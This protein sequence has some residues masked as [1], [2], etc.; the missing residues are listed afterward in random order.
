MVKKSLL[1]KYIQ[2]SWQPPFILLYILFILV[3]LFTD[4]PKSPKLIFP[5]KKISFLNSRLNYLITFYTSSLGS[6]WHRHL[7]Q[8]VSFV[9]LFF[10]VSKYSPQQVFSILHIGTPIPP[11][12]PDTR[13]L[14]LNLTFSPF[15]DI[16]H[17]QILLVLLI[18]ILKCYYF[19]SCYSIP[20][21]IFQIMIAFPNLF[22][23]LKPKEGFKN[24]HS[25]ISLPCL[26]A[27]HWW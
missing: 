12:K 4:K 23:T 10:Y 2:L 20:R 14:F 24:T 21:I 13:E 15:I 25:S 11:L 5:E 22:L 9:E 16:I 19:N 27:S 8:A 6:L 26:I 1:L 18:H 3:D 7:Q 17:D